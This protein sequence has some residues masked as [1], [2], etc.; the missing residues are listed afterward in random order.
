MEVQ[1]AAEILRPTAEELQ[2]QEAEHPEIPGEVVDLE[3]RTTVLYLVL[4]EMLEGLI[5]APTQTHTVI[6]GHH[7][8][9]FH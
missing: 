3:H 4:E 2:R 5:Q 7:L 9:V 1:A 8:E 6:T